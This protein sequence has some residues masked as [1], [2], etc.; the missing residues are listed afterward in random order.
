[1]TYNFSNLVSIHLPRDTGAG[2]SA[3]VKENCLSVP[4]WRN[5]LPQMR[6]TLNMQKELW[7]DLQ[8]KE[9]ENLFL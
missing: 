9:K 3:A 8:K 1:M 2:S 4:F 7:E 6:L 5:I